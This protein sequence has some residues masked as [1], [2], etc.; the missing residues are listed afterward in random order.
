MKR[1]ALP[2]FALLL[3]L[4]GCVTTSV[5]P[6]SSEQYDPIAPEEVT[7]YLSEEDIPR[8]YA[9]VALIQAKGDYQM[10]DQEK[11]F[12]KVREDA[13]EL[14]ANGV[15]FQGMQE[16]ETGAKVAKFFLGTP[17]SRKGEMIAIY[18]FTEDD[19]NDEAPTPDDRQPEEEP[20]D[21]R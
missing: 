15:L 17:A 9:K 20:E 8:N 4:S 16:P 2:L 18:V 14:G 7:I 12:K 5:T 19:E 10:T 11:M 21:Q 1:T 13:A 6:L 3:L